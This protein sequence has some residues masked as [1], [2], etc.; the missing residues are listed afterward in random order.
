MRPEGANKTMTHR[1]GAPLVIG[2]ANIRFKNREFEKSQAFGGMV[3]LRSITSRV[4]R[5]F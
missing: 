5:R 3:I 4:Y 1:K 2:Y